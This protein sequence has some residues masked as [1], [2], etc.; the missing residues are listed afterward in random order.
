MHIIVSTTSKNT[1]LFYNVIMK[2]W[3]ASL[4]EASLLPD[5]LDPE[6]SMNFQLILVENLVPSGVEFYDR[7]VK[8]SFKLDDAYAIPIRRIKAQLNL[9]ETPNP[10]NNP[11]MF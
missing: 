8:K 3:T 2:H 10:Q 1:P 11:V 5:L 6:D 4:E 9:S 7:K